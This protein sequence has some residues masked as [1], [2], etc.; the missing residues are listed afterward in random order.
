MDD[1]GTLEDN[2]AIWFDST[3]LSRTS[4]LTSTNC[5]DADSGN[6]GDTELVFSIFKDVADLAYLMNNFR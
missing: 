5:G 6:A 2:L 3:V 4:R 1:A